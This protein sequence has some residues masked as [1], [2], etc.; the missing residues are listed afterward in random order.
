MLMI[1]TRMEPGLARSMVQGAPDALH[2]EF[3]LS[4]AML[5]NLLLSEAADPESLLKASF[6]Q[7]QVERSLP[8]LNQRITQLEVIAPGTIFARMRISFY[9]HAVAQNWPEQDVMRPAHSACRGMHV[10]PPAI[11][12]MTDAVSALISSFSRSG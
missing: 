1:D 3:H 5:L 7:F 10:M 6:R 2:S 9:R 4:Y 12:C 8:A 11:G